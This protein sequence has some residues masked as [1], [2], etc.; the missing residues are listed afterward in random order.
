MVGDGVNDAA[1]I[2]AATVGIG[3]H[4]GAEASLATADVAMTRDGLAALV[5]LDR[6]AHRAMNV[7]RRNIA[8]A[9]TYNMVAA[10]RRSSQIEVLLPSVAYSDVPHVAVEHGDR[11]W[12]MLDEQPQPLRAVIQRFLG[13]LALA[14]LTKLVLGFDS[15]HLALS[16]RQ[17]QTRQQRAH[18]EAGKQHGHR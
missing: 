2:A 14:D 15:L 8:W 9:F 10:E 11:S 4:G 13:P 5:S 7:I 6:G 17:D 12:G 16:H 18:D 1:A 3:V